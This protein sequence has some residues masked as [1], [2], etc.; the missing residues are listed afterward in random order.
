MTSQDS[1]P[2]GMRLKLGPDLMN[3][4]RGADNIQRGDAKDSVIVSKEESVMSMLRTSMLARL[5]PVI[6][7]M[8]H[9]YFFLQ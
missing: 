9:I 7:T 8:L 1:D 4:S 3:K 5:C 2:V 6:P